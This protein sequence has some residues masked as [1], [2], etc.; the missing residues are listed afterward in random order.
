VQLVVPI[1]P[2]TDDGKRQIDLSAGDHLNRLIYRMAHKRRIAFT[3]LC[4]SIRAA[5]GDSG[6]G[7][8]RRNAS[9]K[10]RKLS[11]KSGPILY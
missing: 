1:R 5:S 4:S 10:L 7:G 8:A 3:H 2:L 11:Q 9:V 6:A